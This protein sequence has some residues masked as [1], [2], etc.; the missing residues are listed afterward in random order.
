MTVMRIDEGVKMD[1]ESTTS[2]TNSFRNKM[3][4]G[5]YSVAQIRD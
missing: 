5:L 2:S 3:R 1:C 4:N